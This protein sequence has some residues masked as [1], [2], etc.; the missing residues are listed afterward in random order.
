M[1]MV[2]LTVQRRLVDRGRE[3]R[4]VIDCC[5]DSICS[6]AL[7]EDTWGGLSVHLNVEVISLTLQVFSDRC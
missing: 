5:C 1:A 3:V 2:P 7:Y 4:M 6:L